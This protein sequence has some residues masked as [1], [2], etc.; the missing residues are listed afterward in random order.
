MPPKHHKSLESPGVWDYGHTDMFV[1]TNC[2]DFTD[3]TQEIRRNKEKNVQVRDRRWFLKV[4]NIHQLQNRKLKLDQTS[5]RK[6]PQ[7]ESTMMTSTYA[8]DFQPPELDDYTFHHPGKSAHIDTLAQPSSTGFQYSSEMHTAYVNTPRTSTK[9][10]FNIL[11]LPSEQC[12]LGGIQ[13]FMDAPNKVRTVSEQR[14]LDQDLLRKKQ[15]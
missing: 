8:G 1:T 13:T 5:D 9:R 6:K 12:K 4:E 14:V 2:V 3:K 10:Q 7:I 15:F 11:I